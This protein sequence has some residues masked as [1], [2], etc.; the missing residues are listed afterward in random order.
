MSSP[1]SRFSD[2]GNLEVHAVMDREVLVDE[3]ATSPVLRDLEPS[4]HFV[5]SVRFSKMDRHLA[6][7]LKGRLL[8]LGAR[9]VRIMELE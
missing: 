6:F 3:F 8:A 2:K 9:E 4:G 5:Y 1:I 7:E